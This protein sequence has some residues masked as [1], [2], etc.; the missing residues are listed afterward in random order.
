MES[1]PYSERAERREIEIKL[2]PILGLCEYFKC[3]KNFAPRILSSMQV[4][5]III[6]VLA[7]QIYG[8]NYNQG[9]LS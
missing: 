1:N 9:P 4:A 7:I 6:C 8:F 5:G 2:C 3:S